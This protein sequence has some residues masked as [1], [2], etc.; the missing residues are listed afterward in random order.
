[1]NFDEVTPQDMRFNP[2]TFNVADVSEKVAK[3]Y[4]LRGKWEPLTGERDQ[5][6]YITMAAGR[7]SVV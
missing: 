4:G 5:N 6:F 1:M 3:A 2:P 7:P